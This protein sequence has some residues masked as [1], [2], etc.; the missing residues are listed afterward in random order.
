MRKNEFVRIFPCR[1]SEIYDKYFVTPRPSNKFLYKYM[2]TDDIIPFPPG[3]PNSGLA[4]SIA[5]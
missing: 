5:D 1:G 3:Y 4:K 2:F